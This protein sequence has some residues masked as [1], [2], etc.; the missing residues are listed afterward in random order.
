MQVTDSIMEIASDA[1]NAAVSNDVETCL[2]AALEAVLSIQGDVVK[3]FV[4]MMEATILNNQINFFKVASIGTQEEFNK[5]QGAIDFMSKI[6][7]TPEYI[8]LKSSISPVS[9]DNLEKVEQPIDTQ[10]NDGWIEE[11]ELT[12][13]IPGFRIRKI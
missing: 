5:Y 2:K 9:E 6:S 7:I 4:D 10:D 12:I 11:L 13:K 3:S 8:A 1:W